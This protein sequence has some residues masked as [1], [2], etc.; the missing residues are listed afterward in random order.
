MTATPSPAAPQ[1][2][3]FDPWLT[4]AA[5]GLVLLKLWLVS[6]QT[7]IAIGPAGHDD[8]SFVYLANSILRG[9]WLGNYSQYTL[10][11][12]P[13]YS[14]FIAGTFLLGVPLFL[15]QQLL[16]IAACG[17]A[18]RALR[19][20]ILCRWVRFVIF[21]VLLF[22]PITYDSLIHQRVL[23]QNIV[24][25]LCLM[26]VAGLIAVYARRRGPKRRLLPWLMLAGSALPAFWMTR[27]EGVWIL[28]CAGL[29]WAA[30]FL[31][32]WRD[33]A[34]DRS[35]RLALL[36]LPGLMWAA[37]IAIVA[38]INLHYY[39]VFTT[40]EFKRTEFKDAFG[41]L[42]R[43]E[44]AHWREYIT[45]PR[46][47]R[48]RLYPLS[49]TFAELK[50]YLEGPGGEGW[51][52]PAEGLTHLPAKEHEMAGWFVWAMR[53]ATAAAGHYHNG[54]DAMAFYGKMA[55]EINEA[56]DSGKIKAGPRRT[57]FLPPL[58]R[59]YLQPLLGTSWGE[60][61]FFSDFEG[62]STD[63]GESSGS[64]ESLVPFA[65]LTRGRL[66]PVPGGAHIPPEQHWLDCIRVSI[67]DKIMRGYKLASPVAG[68]AALLALIFATGLALIR[69]RFSYFLA[70]S[71]GFL[72]S[73]LALVVINSLIEITSFPALNAG[74]FTGGYGLWLFF[75]FTSWL[76]LAEVLWPKAR[77]PATQTGSS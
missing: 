62:L 41:A 68:G 43:V 12:G 25:G 19:P 63:S 56:C 22:N 18:T 70:V 36:T 4:S 51:S 5:A 20:L 66:S 1:K 35:A 14:L 74:Y 59:E 29:L 13:M 44:P 9:Q 73:V 58:R 60:L 27:E 77:T 17:L 64:P 8:A 38:L 61:R 76:A 57:G 40:C 67:L 31:A 28:P 24:P 21:T 33:H 53:D 3:R 47:V 75:M 48:E 52:I 71:I 7:I 6:A 15:A 50:P 34:A 32:V 10:M 72:G 23:R 26:I 42:L 30:A 46:E 49:P 37:G 69:L 16:Y 11:K 45:V 55:R 39:G 2:S 65:D 54:A